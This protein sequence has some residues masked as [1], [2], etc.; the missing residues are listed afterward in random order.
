MGRADGFGGFDTPFWERPTTDWRPLVDAGLR[1]HYVASVH[2]ARAMVAA[3]SGLIVHISPFGSRRHLHSV[4]YGVAK[5][6]LDKMAADMAVE[7]Q[8]TGVHAIPS[9]RLGGGGLF[10]PG[11]SATTVG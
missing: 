10:G 11:G 8:G 1:A 9:G 2:A 5:T 4:L 3:G 6:G 7:L